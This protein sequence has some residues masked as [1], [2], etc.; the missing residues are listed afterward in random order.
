MKVKEFFLVAGNEDAAATG[1]DVPAD[2]GVGC[3]VR[4]ERG[5]EVSVGGL[6]LEE[7]PVCALTV[8]GKTLMKWEMELRSLLLNKL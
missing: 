7:H 4:A 3:V 8:C 5:H 6:G 2:V 1:D